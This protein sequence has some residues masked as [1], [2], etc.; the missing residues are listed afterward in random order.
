MWHTYA[1]LSHYHHPEPLS[2]RPESFGLSASPM[3]RPNTRNVHSLWTKIVCNLLTETCDPHKQFSVSPQAPP[4]KKGRKPPTKSRESIGPIKLQK[5]AARQPSPVNWNC[6]DSTTLDPRVG[7]SILP[8][9]ASSTYKMQHQMEPIIALG[10]QSSMDHHGS[11]SVLQV[12]PVVFEHSIWHS[13]KSKT[14]WAGFFASL[15]HVSSATPHGHG[16]VGH[17][18]SK[19]QPE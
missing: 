1:H 3:T 2:P 12:Q 10:I 15:Q 13:K 17:V 4:K 19:L 16:H 9:E 5:V 11:T 14:F 6:D 18:P 8:R 7:V